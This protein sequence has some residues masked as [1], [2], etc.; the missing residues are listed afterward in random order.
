MKTMSDLVS[1]FDGLFTVFISQSNQTLNF[2]KNGKWG[3]C[4]T[5]TGGVYLAEPLLSTTL[6]N[7][8]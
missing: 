5:L 2:H 7:T 3:C 6:S 8:S 4:T 1:H